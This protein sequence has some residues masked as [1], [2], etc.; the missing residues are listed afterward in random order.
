MTSLPRSMIKST[1]R[2]TSF[3]LDDVGI[4][5]L[6]VAT[7]PGILDLSGFCKCNADILDVGLTQHERL[8]EPNHDLEEPHGSLGREIAHEVRGCQ[9]LLFFNKFIDR[10]FLNIA[11]MSREHVANIGLF[12]PL[13]FLG[14]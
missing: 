2:W 10:G 6:S 14:A 12:L 9:R 4:L 7:A 13:L 8:K 5:G 1:H 3:A 11:L